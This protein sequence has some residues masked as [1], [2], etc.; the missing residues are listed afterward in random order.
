MMCTDS[1]TIEKSKGAMK[2]IGNLQTLPT[3]EIEREQTKQKNPA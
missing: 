2:K 1:K 3:L